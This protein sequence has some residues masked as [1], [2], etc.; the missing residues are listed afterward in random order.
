MDIS[1]KTLIIA[2][3]INVVLIAICAVCL[4]ITKW[5]PVVIWISL[6]LLVLVLITSII[7]YVLGK[8]FKK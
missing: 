6:A 1:R 2:V 3:I 4:I 5:N 7:T 8:N